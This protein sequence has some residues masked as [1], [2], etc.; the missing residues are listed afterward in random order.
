MTKEEV[1]LKAV[2]MYKEVAEN[3]I[4]EFGVDMGD[5]EEEVEELKKEWEEAE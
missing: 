1:F 5:L 2:R 4:D 3:V